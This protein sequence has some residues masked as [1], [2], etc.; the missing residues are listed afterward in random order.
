MNISNIA[1]TTVNVI[2]KEVFEA[3]DKGVN[4]T[5]NKVESKL[6]ELEVGEDKIEAVLQVIDKDDPF[7][8]ARK[9]LEKEKQR[10]N[11]INSSFPNVKSETVVLSS[12]DDP[13]KESYQYVSVKDSLKVLLEDESFIKQ[14]VND[15]Y[16][17]DENVI[18]DVRDGD[19]FL[20]NTFFNDNPEAVPL[21]VFVDELE[22]C[23]PLGAGKTKHKINCTYVSNLEVQPALRSKVK[24]IQLVSLVLSKVW[25]KHGNEACNRRFVA[26]LKELEDVGIQINVPVK[27]TI[28]AGLAYLV[29]DNLGQHNLAEMNQC[30][31]AGCICRWCK[32]TYEDVTGSCFWDDQDISKPAE[33]TVDAYDN[34]ADLA[35]EEEDQET[36]GVK[37]HC[38]FNQLQAFHCIKQC[39]PCLG[40]DFYEVNNCSFIFLILIYI[41]FR[42]SWPM[43]SSSTW[44]TSS[45]RRSL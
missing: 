25:K 12:R 16:Y 7:Q 39:P 31:S 20:T 32:A 45:R 6:R 13:K 35:G 10:I 24:S 43:T 41:N 34:Y 17:F 36:Y 2:I 26:D 29:G 40:H 30:F 8:T 4:F 38:T 37:R 21:L 33:W 11:F 5:R 27:K 44:S 14:K 22:I 1:Y 15:P 18:K 23:N 3:Y 28:K 19:C 9:Q 42:G